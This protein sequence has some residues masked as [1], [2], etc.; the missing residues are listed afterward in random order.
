MSNLHGSG[1]ETTP[2]GVCHRNLL[3]GFRSVGTGRAHYRHL[4]IGRF[5][6]PFLRTERPAYRNYALQ[7]FTNFRVHTWPYDEAPRTF[8][9]FMGSQLTTGYDL[10]KWEETRSIGQ[11]YGSAIF[12]PNDSPSSTCRPSCLSRQVITP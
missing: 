6:R 11:Q 12:K 10:Y 5:P 9:G 3:R 7:N 4:G 2:F 8:Y 1:Y